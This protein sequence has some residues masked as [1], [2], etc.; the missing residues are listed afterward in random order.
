MRQLVVKVAYVES[1]SKY[2]YADVR[3][4]RQTCALFQLHTCTSM[5]SDC[6]VCLASVVRCTYD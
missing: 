6:V 2:I 5:H 4:L 3:A 1:E